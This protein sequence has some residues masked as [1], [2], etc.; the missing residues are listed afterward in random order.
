MSIDLLTKKHEE[1]VR[2]T[3]HWNASLQFEVS[4]PVPKIDLHPLLAGLEFKQQDLFDLL[5]PEVGGH[6]SALL[7]WYFSPKEFPPDGDFK[8]SKVSWPKLKLALLQACPSNGYRLVANG[9]NAS[10]IRILYCSRH[11]PSRL[12]FAKAHTPSDYRTDHLRSNR[13]AGSRGEAGRK[14]PRRFDS[15]K[16]PSANECCKVRLSIGVDYQGFFLIGKNGWRQHTFHPREGDK[17]TLPPAKLNAIPAVGRHFVDTLRTAGLSLNATSFAFQREYGTTLTTSQI[18]YMT[19]TINYILP[20]GGVRKK[21][22]LKT[23]SADRLLQDLCRNKHDHIVLTHQTVG[24]AMTVH[25]NTG[26]TIE[27]DLTFTKFWPEP[28]RSSVNAYIAKQRRARAIPIEQDLFVAILWITK[29]EKEM[30]R[31]FPYVMKIDTTFGT[32]DRSMPLLSITGLDSNNKTFTVARA[33]IPNEQSWVFRWILTHA[34][35]GLLGID[36]MQRIVVILSDGDSTEIVQINNLIDKLCPQVHRLRCGW[37]LVD[38]GWE[39]LIYHIPKDPFR[40]KFRLFETTRRIL[41]SWSYSW[42]TPACE[43]KEEYTL[44]LQLFQRFLESKELMSMV[45]PFFLE[46]IRDWHNTVLACEPNWVFYRRK[47]LFAREEYTNSSHEASF[48]QVKYGF[49]ALAPG[50]DVH[51]SG[52]NLN[53][54]ANVTYQRTK[55]LANKQQTRFASWSTIPNL[56]SRLTRRGAGLAEAQWNRRFNYHSMFLPTTSNFRLIVSGSASDLPTAGSSRNNTPTNRLFTTIFFPN[57]RRVRTV[58]LVTNPKGETRLQCSC[59]FP[60]RVGIP[61][62][63]QQHVL[64]TYYEDYSPKMEDVHPFWWTTYL[65]HS[66]LREEGVSRTALSKNL[67]EIVGVYDN[68][69]Y[70]G[71]V[72]PQCGP[73]IIE[74]SSNHLSDFEDLEIEDRVMNWSREELEKVLP[75]AWKQTIE[76]N[77]HCEVNTSRPVPGLSQQSFTFSQGQDCSSDS[78]DNDGVSFPPWKER[79]EKDHCQLRRSSPCTNNDNPHSVLSPIFKMLVAAVEKDKGN[80]KDTEAQLLDLVACVEGKVNKLAVEEEGVLALPNSKRIRV[81]QRH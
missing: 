45:G 80:L 23:T 65:M 38:R 55:S 75:K 47:S 10:H 24:D 56:T 26:T 69:P 79:F 1:L 48:R 62:R 9:S 35:P 43:T 30:F 63:H 72:V 53:T 49:A 5:S 71:P 57:Y 32:N 59:Y 11:R 13:R 8:S 27:E 16:A 46:K 14:M 61:C 64:D 36:T 54:Q 76:G 77:G 68:E 15:Y 3:Q 73:S 60:N 52:K 18:R 74:T 21:Q 7:R 19:Q 17:S 28:E 4:T 33:Y 67:E 42:M 29:G 41:F 12:S 22:E 81:N 20:P 70:T 34:L 25:K 37:H 39:R 40:S 6:A 51:E 31:K 78:D 50:M 44:S 2:H 58:Q 66:F